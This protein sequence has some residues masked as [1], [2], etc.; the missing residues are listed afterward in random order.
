MRRDKLIYTNRF[1]HLEAKHWKDM[2]KLHEVLL[3]LPNYF[4]AISIGPLE[5]PMTRQ[6]LLY[7]LMITKKRFKYLHAIVFSIRWV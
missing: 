4:K 1:R 2:D 5:K 3:S 6:D 7:S